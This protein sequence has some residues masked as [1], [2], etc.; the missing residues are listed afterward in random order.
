MEETADLGNGV[1]FSS[2]REGDLLVR[3]DDHPA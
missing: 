3:S 2:V 1:V